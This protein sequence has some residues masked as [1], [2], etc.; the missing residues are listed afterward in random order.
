MTTTRKENRI[1]T[2]EEGGTYKILIFGVGEAA[3]GEIEESLDKVE[4]KDGDFP[5]E[6]PLFQTVNLGSPHANPS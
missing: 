1:F 3:I 5:H 4:Q 6:W 2:H